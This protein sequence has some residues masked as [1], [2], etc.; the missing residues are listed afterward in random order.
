MCII[1]PAII[2]VFVV[3][4]VIRLRNAPDTLG[5][6]QELLVQVSELA[7]TIGELSTRGLQFPSQCCGATLPSPA[8]CHA[9][10]ALQLLDRRRVSRFR[11]EHPYQRCVP[12]Q[13][14][15]HEHRQP[16]RARFAT[17]PSLL[18]G[19]YGVTIWL[20]IV[21]ITSL[22]VPAI[23]SLSISAQDAP[24]ASSTRLLASSRW[25]TCG[26]RRASLVAPHPL[27]RLDSADG[28]DHSLQGSSIPSR[29]TPVA[30][31]ADL[32]EEQPDS[33]RR[34]KVER[35]RPRDY[36]TILA[37]SIVRRDII[38][39]PPTGPE[40]LAVMMLPPGGVLLDARALTVVTAVLVCS[41]RGIAMLRRILEREFCVE[42]AA[43]ATDAFVLREMTIGAE[44]AVLA[45][46][47]TTQSS[48]PRPDG[49]LATLAPPPAVVA[50]ASQGS[51]EAGT[52]GTKP[53]GHRA[54]RRRSTGAHADAGACLGRMRSLLDLYVTPAAEARVNLSN[55]NAKALSSAMAELGKSIDET[56]V[57]GRVDALHSVQAALTTAEAEVF[58]LLK[59]GPVFR[60][61][62]SE[63]YKTWASA[64]V[65]SLRGVANRRTPA[66]V[67]E[68]APSPA[69]AGGIAQ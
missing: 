66:A 18:A 45:I 50:G 69:D 49:S 62:Q 6:R 3:P 12:R 30:A 5:F 55:R 7:G 4:I 58:G 27:I 65:T 64:V 2:I 13:A 9:P 52:E 54:S 41:R 40:L 8:A 39:P 16:F 15:T 43:F 28:A 37:A 32:D 33:D 59:H 34:P 68:A 19:E 23:L 20:D 56:A 60:F 48:S 38:S 10:S 36:A 51:S 57:A 44:A 61:V 22:W 14:S 1:A 21:S 42:N 24:E 11:D 31:P 46:E 35:G 29:G 47:S 63:E 26:S 25:C 53:R 17:A 67:S